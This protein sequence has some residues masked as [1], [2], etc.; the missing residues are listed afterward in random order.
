MSN[1]NIIDLWNDNEFT[2]DEEKLIIKGPINKNM[3]RINLEFIYDKKN[4]NLYTLQKTNSYNN[5]DLIFDENIVIIKNLSKSDIYRGS[6][7]MILALQIIYKLGYKIAQLKDMAYFIC[8]RKMNFFSNKENIISSRMEISN[9]LIYLFRFGGTFYMP[10]GFIPIITDEKLSQVILNNREKS[11]IINEK[12]NNY[13]NISKLIDLLLESLFNISW[14]DINNYI[15][16]IE[17]LLNSNE[18]KMSNRIFNWR[19][20]DYNIWKIYW[21]NICKSWKKFNEKYSSIVTG[22]F[23]AFSL[24]NK[25]ECNLFINWLELYSFS[26][27]QTMVYNSSIFNNKLS[28]KKNVTGIDNFKKLKSLLEKAEWINFN[29][30]RQPIRSI[31]TESI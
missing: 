12:Y 21:K 20:R 23:F 6:E 19:V 29:I 5:I 24:Y 4:N 14:L 3:V 26:I 2:L 28:E 1:E 8:D 7:Y 18:Y 31:F 27:D 25:I 15:L 10:F 16:G 17:T 11:L 9:K 13:K 30:I 22:P